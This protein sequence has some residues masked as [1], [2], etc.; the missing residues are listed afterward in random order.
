MNIII[1][2]LLINYEII[3]KNKKIVLFI[4]GWGDDYNNL[5]L[6][7]QELKKNYQLVFLDLPGF[8]ASQ[9]PPL[10]YNLDRYALIIGDFV[11][12]LNLKVNILIAHSFGG[13]V[14]IKA[15]SRGYL[16][17]DKLV[18]I[19]SSGIRFT[20]L[21]K[22]RLKKLYITPAKVILSP[23]PKKLQNK[24]IKNYYSRRGSDLYLRED[25][26]PIFRNI[27]AEDIR[28]DAT[29]IKIPTLL[30]YGQQD[31]ETP[32]Q[33]GYLLH[34]A[35]DGSTLEVI[36]SAGHFVFKDRAERVLKLVQEFL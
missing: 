9:Q 3:G 13:S 16:T 6:A 24:I 15:L 23:L 29:L 11:T 2:N 8:G 22:N 12:K 33:Y 31:Q 18:L 26:M 17:A 36:N 34:E 5:K 20:S 7:F 14:V 21:K 28:K 35:I 4:H 32:V 25:M 30:I 10:N 19:A 1:N 27:V